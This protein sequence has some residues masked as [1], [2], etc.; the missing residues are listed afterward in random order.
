MKKLLFLFILLLVNCNLFAVSARPIPLCMQQKDGT[1]ITIF[2]RGDE[3]FHYYVTEDDVPLLQGTDLSFYYATVSGSTLIASGILAHNLDQRS[4]KESIFVRKT[5]EKALSAIE[6]GYMKLQKRKIKQRN[7]FYS[8]TQ[9]IFGV[10]C[11]YLGKKKGLVIL[12]DFLDKAM[13]D[14]PQEEF[15]RL[16]NQIGYDKNNHIGSVH[17]YFYDQSYGKFDLSFD[18]IGP[19]TVSRPLSYYGANSS[20]NSQTDM[21]VG[22]MVT[23]ACKLADKDVDFSNYDWDGDG[24]VEQVFIIYSGYGES[25][26]APSYTIWPHKSDLESRS[27]YGDGE[28]I[29]CL[30]GVFINDYACSCELA[31]TAGNILN[32]IGTACHELSHCLGIPDFY[33]VRYNGGFGMSS[34][35][36]MDSGSHNGPGCNGEVPCGYTAYE[37]WFAGWLSFTELKE[38]SRIKDMPCISE[39]PVAY[40]IVNDNNP[41]EYF[42]LENRQNKDWFSY[43]GVSNNCHGLLISHVDYDSLS[44]VKNVVNTEPDHQRM[45]IIPADNDYGYFFEGNSQ[46]RYM[47]TEEDFKGDLFPGC[48][49]IKEFTGDSHIGVGGK[50]FNFDVDGS[51]FFHKPITNIKEYDRNISFDFMGGIYVSRPYIDNFRILDSRSFYVSWFSEGDI[52]SYTIEATE[53][54]GR[55]PY[56]CIALSENFS[57]F[58][59]ETV[60]VD[61]MM[62]LSPYLNSYMQKE[63]WT[64]KGIYVSPIGIKIGDMS[65][66]GFLMTPPVNIITKNIT[67]KIVISKKENLSD[68]INIVLLDR[69]NNTIRNESVL[70][71]VTNVTNVLT[72]EGIEE[73]DYVISFDSE[74]PFYMEHFVCYDGKFSEADVL[75]PIT[76]F[77]KPLEHIEVSDIVDTHYTFDNMSAQKYKIRLKAMKD[78]AFSEWTP[79]AEI[80]FSGVNGIP[81]IQ[82]IGNGNVM[83]VYTINGVKVSNMD[84]KGVYVIDNGLYS[85]KTIVNK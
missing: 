23:E 43:V 60:G 12:V 52:D 67:L 34:W 66:S 32:G 38:M 71:N 17:D 58:R 29:L 77:I 28:G 21:N 15:N 45:S 44:W 62:E 53:V 41:N 37:R 74:S 80:D 22:Q 31:G 10:S 57:N 4:N 11:K 7:T 56:E 14:N 61:G 36:P 26:G 42:I 5:K 63:G 73:G 83:N 59:S 33:N 1:Q 16:F 27:Y 78:E 8:K 2:L 39:Q 65:K 76:S 84:R 55:N 47:P 82:E 46:K 24:I 72:F 85:R 30:D 79:Y 75:A 49:G 18:V 19:V 51:Y 40:K 6:I 81:Q 64:G 9:N 20:W 3:T 54:R 25:S 69:M 70:G 35:D 48:K 68:P 13:G 50:W